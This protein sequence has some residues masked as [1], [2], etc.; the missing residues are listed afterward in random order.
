LRHRSLCGWLLGRGLRRI[1]KTVTETSDG[2]DEQRI[3]GIHFDLLSKAKYV[4]V[5]GAIGNGAI[6]APNGVEQLFA[7]YP[8]TPLQED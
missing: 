1:A 4:H 2:P 7:A 8:I 6:V 3:R 5:Y